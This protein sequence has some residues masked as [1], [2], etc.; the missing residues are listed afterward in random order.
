M[1]MARGARKISKIGWGNAPKIRPTRPTTGL[2]ADKAFY[3]E[4]SGN[5]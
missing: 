1:Q 5:P 2:E 4:H 3:D